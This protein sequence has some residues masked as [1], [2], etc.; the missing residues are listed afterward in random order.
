M[1]KSSG[2][3]SGID[4]HRPSETHPIVAGMTGQFFLEISMFN[5]SP[6]ETLASY[7]IA[8][9]AGAVSVFAIVAYGKWMK[10]QGRQI[11]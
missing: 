7:A 4:P 11:G 6:I 5:Q 1:Q 9:A 3:S 8:F 2:A 10:H